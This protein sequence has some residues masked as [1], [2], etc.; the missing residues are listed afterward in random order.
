MRRLHGTGAP[1]NGR[2]IECRGPSRRNDYLDADSPA[3]VTQGSQQCHQVHHEGLRADDE[4]TGMSA[5]PENG[6]PRGTTRRKKPELPREKPRGFTLLIWAADFVQHG[7]TDTRMNNQRPQRT[8]EDRMSICGF[9]E[10]QVALALD[11]A[12]GIARAGEAV[13]FQKEVRPLLSHQCFKCHGPDDNARKAGFRLDLREDA[14][15]PA[16]S[17]AQTDCPRQTRLERTGQ[18]RHLL[19]GFR[20]GH[21]SAP[22]RPNGKSSK[23]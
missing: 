20:R 18:K 4:E 1:K 16:K 23:K 12:G 2:R 3:L 14:L 10:L 21:T 15:R 5:K 11:L 6:F 7:I 22:E 8:F 19:P 17:G 9:V 13:D